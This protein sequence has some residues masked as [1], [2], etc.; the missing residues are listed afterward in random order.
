MHIRSESSL[1]VSLFSFHHVGPAASAFIPWDNADEAFLCVINSNG[2]FASIH[3]MQRLGCLERAG[4]T[5]LTLALTSPHREEGGIE[6]TSICVPV[7][8]NTTQ[9]GTGTY[10]SGH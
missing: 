3:E 6:I 8:T 5:L 9:K 10:R 7:I 2:D 1:Q 4:G